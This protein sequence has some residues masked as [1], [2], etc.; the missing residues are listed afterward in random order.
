MTQI[1]GAPPDIVLLDTMLPDGRGVD[2]CARAT[3][4]HALV[5]QMPLAIDDVP[6]C[7]AAQRAGLIAPPHRRPSSVDVRV[8]DITM[9]L[10]ASDPDRRPRS[11][12]ELLDA[13]ARLLARL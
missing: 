10:L 7:M 6:R 11:D 5:G 4:Y 3:L 9:W 12:D 13:L 1:D 2:V 8:S